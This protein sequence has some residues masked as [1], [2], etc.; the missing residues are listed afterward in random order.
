MDTLDDLTAGRKRLAIFAEE[1]RGEAFLP[2]VDCGALLSLEAAFVERPIDPANRAY[3]IY[4]RADAVDPLLALAAAKC[5]LHRGEEVGDEQRRTLAAALGIGEDEVTQFLAMPP[6][7]QRQ[8]DAL[9]RAP[10]DKLDRLRR[11]RDQN[12]R[13]RGWRRILALPEPDEALDPAELAA[14]EREELDQML[15]GTKPLSMFGDWAPE[16][17]FQPHVDRGAFL[18]LDVAVAESP[19]G[20]FNIPRTYYVMPGETARLRHLLMVERQVFRRERPADDDYDREVGRALGYSEA[21]IERYVAGGP[22]RR[23]ARRRYTMEKFGFDPTDPEA[24][25]HRLHTRSSQS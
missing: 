8:P 14:A 15:A 25:R 16:E 1:D 24:V 6:I 9:P 22:A 18:R 11:T 21:D 12:A 20:T 5:G 23:D 10:M 13:E 2:H 17:A 19:V 4:A 3:V 7:L